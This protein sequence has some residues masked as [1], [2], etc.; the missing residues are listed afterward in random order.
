MNEIDKAAEYFQKSHEITLSIDAKHEM[1]QNLKYLVFSKV[2]LHELS[3][4][5]SLMDIFGETYLFL[6]KEDTLQSIIGLTDNNI[7]SI[8]KTQLIDKIF[9][10]SSLML[11]IMCFIILIYNLVYKK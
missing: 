6:S 7:T 5:D 1:L 8:V 11:V 3:S 10:I 2:T 4:A 9:A